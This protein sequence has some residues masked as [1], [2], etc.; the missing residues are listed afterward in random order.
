MKGVEGMRSMTPSQRIDALLR[1]VE[2]HATTLSLFTNE[3]TDVKK[4]LAQMSI[5]KAVREQVD[6]GLNE[7]LARIEKSIEVLTGTIDRKF[8]PISR[9]LIWFGS[10]VGA[11]LLVAI[12]KFLISGT[13]TVAPFIP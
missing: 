13:L 6:K 3:L 12:V 4:V 1:N 11:A 7:R 8:A 9:T 2:A 10:V 5:D